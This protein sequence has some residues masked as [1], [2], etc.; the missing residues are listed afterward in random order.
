MHD[1]SQVL[2]TG[3]GHQLE[4]TADARLALDQDLGQILDVQLRIGQQ[5]QDPQARGLASAAKRGERLVGR[6]AWNS[7][8]VRYFF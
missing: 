3:L 8:G 5:R 1:A 7:A 4:V 6:K 2:D